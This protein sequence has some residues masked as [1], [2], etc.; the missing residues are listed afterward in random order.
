MENIII[1]NQEKFEELKEKFKKD[2][3]EKLHVLADFD[4]TLTKVFVNEKKIPSLISVLIDEKYLTPDYPEKARALYDKYSAIERD[5]SIPLEERK[6]A[7]QE[8]WT[9][10]FELLI[11]SGLSKKDLEKAVKSEN[12]ILREEIPK[13]LNNLALNKIPLVILSSSGLGDESIALY[14]KNKKLL[15]DNIHI[16]CNSFNW[17]ENGNAVSVKQPIIHILN[18]TETV[19]KNFT[20]IFMRVKDRTNVILLGDSISDIDMVVGFDYDNIIKIGFLNEE[21]EEKL[22]KYKEVY[23]VII[24]NDGSAEFLNELLNHIGVV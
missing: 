24:A 2:G 17:D 8:W 9:K 5:L 22:E 4:K 16:I 19:V 20:D 7:M 15:S 3:V 10:H 14:L 6:S 18:K 21:V 12:F 23:D 11:S 13:F 1:S